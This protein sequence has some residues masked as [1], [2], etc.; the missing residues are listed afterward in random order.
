VAA[1]HAP[2]E[3]DAR[4]EDT[5]NGTRRRAA[6]NPQPDRLMGMRPGQSEEKVRLLKNLERSARAEEKL[7]IKA[8]DHQLS[9]EQGSPQSPR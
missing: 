2:E 6:G 9:L 4:L 7:R 3:Q 1:V 5:A 8:L